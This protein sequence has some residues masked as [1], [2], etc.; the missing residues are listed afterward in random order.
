ML[1][2][3]SLTCNC[4]SQKSICGDYEQRHIY[5]IK[6]NSIILK[7]IFNSIPTLTFLGLNKKNISFNLMMM[8]NDHKVLLLERTESFYYT[9]VVKDLKLNKINFNLLE[10]LYTSEA[11]KII[12]DFCNFIPSFDPKIEKNNKPPKFVRIF[13]GGHCNYNEKIILTLLREFKEETS[14]NINI[15]NLSFNQTCI[16]KV[17]IFD[18]MVK[19]TFNNFVFPVKINMSSVEILRN[20]KETKH[21]RNPTFIDISKSSSLFDTFVQVQ[22]AMLL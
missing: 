20:F 13:P 3:S 9:K 1:L 15:K 17:L 18:L 10:S 6:V 12:N 2:R 5:K 22:K 4:D 16:F 21:V 11:E 8:T 14:I 7:E 19:K